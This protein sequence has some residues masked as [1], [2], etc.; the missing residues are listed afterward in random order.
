MLKIETAGI[1]IVKDEFFRNFPNDKCMDNKHES[2]P[3]FYAVKDD[4]G[5]YWMIPMSS[6]VEK[7]RGKIREVEQKVGIG[8]CFLF[9]I[10]EVSGRERAFIISEMFP[11]TEYYILRPYKVGGSPLVIRN[12]TVQKRLTQKSKKFLSMLA[13]GRIKSPINAL[14]IK[15][16]LLQSK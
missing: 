1:Y 5:L 3:H 10:A 16:Q 6:K 12:Q 9:D 4:N 15:Q 13:G 14:E 8:K 7:F 11:V 2:R